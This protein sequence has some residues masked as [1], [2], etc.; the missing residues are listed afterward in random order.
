MVLS[1]GAKVAGEFAGVG[2]K[3]LSDRVGRRPVVSSD[4]ST[5]RIRVQGRDV[6]LH[7]WHEGFL[8]T[9]V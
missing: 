4:L 6:T 8:E 5:Y 9:V 3:G 1:G 2:V 7:R